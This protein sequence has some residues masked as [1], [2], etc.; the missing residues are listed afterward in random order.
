MSVL[1]SVWSRI[2]TKLYLALGIAV[3]LTL[4]SAGVGVFHFEL[5]GDL[6]H[7]VET[8][9]VPALQGMGEVSR[10]ADRLGSLGALFLADARAGRLGPASWDVD[11]LLSGLEG[12]L[13]RPAGLPGLE[14]E[15]AR[16]HDAAFTLAEVVDRLEV[17]RTAAAD[18]SRL[19]G[20]V[21]SA[22]SSEFAQGGDAGVVMVL[23]E[24]LRAPGP[25]ALEALWAR[26]SGMAP[27]GGVAPSLL[28]L[29]ESPEA[30][31]FAL[32]S[33]QFLLSE[34]LDLHEGELAAARSRMDSSLASMRGAVELR[35]ASY[36]DA[37][38][39]SFDRGRV[40]LAAISLSSVLVA[41]LTA[42]VWVGNGIV[43]RLSMLS[44]RMR[45]MAE[46]DFDTPVPGVGADEIGRL[47]DALEVFRQWALE[48][49]RLNLVERLYGELR[50]AHEELGR[51]QGR[52][53]AQ[54]KLAAL[55]GLVSGV[56]HELSNPLNF[57]KNFSE[58]TV[59]LSDELFEM[60]DNYRGQ[61]SEGDAGLLDEMK[62]DMEDS[63]DRVKVNCLRALTIVRRM[64][65]IGVVGGSPEM[66][67]LHAA[68][69]RSVQVGCDSFQ[70][71]WQDFRVEP[72]YEL[73]GDV[74]QGAVVAAD[75]G[76]AMVNLVTNAC[77]AMRMRGEREDG[78]YTPDLLV[79]TGFSEDGGCVE[80]RVRDN[81]TGIADDVVGRIFDPFFTTRDGALGAG[82][83][84][85]L[86]A[87][88]A[89]RGGGDLTVDTE[90]GVYSE[91][92]FTV[93]LDLPSAT[94]A[95]AASAGAASARL[96]G[97][98][99]FFSPGALA[100]GG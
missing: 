44:G 13:A 68:V 77:Y 90:L 25:G 28:S 14:E 65:S 9:A 23:T 74:R 48:V 6:N 64:Q 41:T 43:R 59:E 16:V 11:G 17:D 76:E 19:A 92:T 18:Q 33:G 82:L 8:E 52:L 60:L 55:G 29:A 63:L 4:L 32:R 21:F 12:S 38:V 93:P 97:D 70:A 51:M 62:G 87:D 42:W 75:F 96:T 94:P 81:G 26:Y 56:A 72:R 69:R 89:R 15:A 83:G 47:A 20:E 71:E 98:S 24:A 46:G 84:L 66:T 61:F 88:V 57:V 5:S 30:G 79:S 78:P 37:A 34:R 27:P 1:L 95:G 22:L 73:S 2:A 50:E 58:G 54:E 80:V 3:V 45:D 86:A 39:E 85:P 91:F 10:S 100:P 40:L 7:R 53:V 36:L 49:Q 31:V 99:G 67:D 35:S